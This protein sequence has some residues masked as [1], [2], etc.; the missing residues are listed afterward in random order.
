MTKEGGLPLMVVFSAKDI[1]PRARNALAASPIFALHEITVK[2]AG[3]A[4]LL[5]GIVTSFYHKQ[6]AQEAVRAVA[7]GVEVVNSIDVF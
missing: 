3:D 1:E 6:L 4:L 7:E 2:R 5:S